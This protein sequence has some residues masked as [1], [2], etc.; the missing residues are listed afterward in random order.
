MA[1][2]GRGHERRRELQDFTLVVNEDIRTQL[3]HHVGRHWMIDQLTVADIEDM[4]PFVPEDTT[5]VVD[6]CCG[7]G[8][9]A[10]AL[11]KLSLHGKAKFWLVDGNVRAEVENIKRHWDK[12]RN[13]EIARFYNKRE[14]TE[15]CCRLNDFNN[16]E[17]VEVD[18]NLQWSKLPTDVDFLF[19]NRGIG[20]HW[21]LG[22]YA[23]TFPKILKAGATCIFMNGEVLGE[24]PEYF[25]KI[26]VVQ[27]K[28]QDRELIVLRY[29]G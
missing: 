24:I 21:P 18:E 16:Y 17:Y 8:R 29:N 19:S 5:Q 3:T 23:A 1:V 2:P 27:E 20:C 6:L 11:D 25:S 26:A 12:Y 13:D 28:I 15:E 14:L 7:S 4:L 22:L 9:V 10:I